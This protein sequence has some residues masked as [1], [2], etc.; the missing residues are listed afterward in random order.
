MKLIRLMEEKLDK[1]T[2][3]AGAASASTLMTGLGAGLMTL[4]PVGTIAGSAILAAGISGG[5]NTIQ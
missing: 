5:I 4:G 3:V 1:K 2:K